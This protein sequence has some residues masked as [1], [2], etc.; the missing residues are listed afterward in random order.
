[1]RDETKNLLDIIHK[2]PAGREGAVGSNDDDE[3]EEE[4]RRLEDDG[5]DELI[6]SEE[7][8]WVPWSLRRPPAFSSD[9]KIE[10]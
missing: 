8:A 5:N 9:L 10:I 3:E 4:D 7:T 2:R 6:G 1:M